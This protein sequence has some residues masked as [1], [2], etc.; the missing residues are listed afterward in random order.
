MDLITVAQAIHW[1]D[2]TSFFAEAFR[3]LKPGGILAAWGYGHHEVK[4]C[5]ELLDHFYHNIVGPF[6]PPERESIENRY[7]DIPLPSWFSENQLSPPEISMKAH[8][9][10]HALVGY[11]STWSAREQYRKARGEDPIQ[12]L[13]EMLDDC[14]KDK[15]EKREVRWPIF[16]LIGRK[17]TIE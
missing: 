11:M 2:H 5:R 1:F 8:W 6:W 16:F 15:E 3:V 9:D 12:L 14:W 10:R 4:G 13:E 7:S 17:P